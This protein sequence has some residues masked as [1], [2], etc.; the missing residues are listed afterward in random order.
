MTAEQ[1][2][3]IEKVLAAAMDLE[4]PE[5]C[6]YLDRACQ[7]RP[8]VRAEVDALLA[9]HQ[10][11]GDFIEAAIASEA[12][13]AEP[14]DA[15]LLSRRIG[16]YKL[17]KE[18][19]R[20]GMATV[21]LG[22]RDDRK[23]SKDVAIKL[24]GAPAPSPVSLR[25]FEEE[26]QILATLEHPNIARLLDGGVT[27]DG[28]HYI[29]MEYVEG[30][31]IDEYCDR[32]SLK[33]EQRLRLF[34]VICS[35]VYF[36]H[37]HLVVHRDIK[38][39]NI[40]VTAE[41]A[42]KLLDFGIAKILAPVQHATLTQAAPTLVPAMTPEYASPEQLQGGIVTTASD[43]Y[44]LGVLL[45]RLLSGAQPYRITGATLGETLRMVCEQDPEKPSAAANR[46]E[47]RG[48]LDAIVLKAMR[49][50]PRERY[51][52]PEEFAGDIG[53]YLSKWPVLARR[54]SNRY[55]LRKFVERHRLAIAITAVATL[56]TLAGVVGVVMESRVARAERAKAERRFNDVRR[57]A[58]SVI[59]EMHDGIAALPGSTPV[60][61]LLVTKATEYLD[62][63]A[64]E[65]RGDDSLQRELADAY[66]R[67]GD[68]QGGPSF[69]NL[70]DTKGAF[71][72]YQKA[73][74]ILQTVVGR[75][76]NMKQ[77]RFLLADVNGRLA[78]AYLAIH[79][80]PHAMD[81][82]KEELSGREEIARQSHQDKESSYAVA[83]AH[84]RLA[85]VMLATRK[86]DQ[87]IA[88]F[89]NCLKM[90]ESLLVT[91]P[92]D[93]NDQ[94]N[95][96]LDHKYLCTAYE[97]G[98]DLAKAAEHCQLA[99][100]LDERRAAAHPAD[101]QAK[102]DLGYSLS[103]TGT[104]YEKKGSL[105]AAFQSF[106]RSLSIR[107]AVAD[108]DPQNVSARASLVFPHLALGDVLT[109]MGKM[110]EAVGQ[111]RMAAQIGEPLIA[112]DP[113]KSQPRE[114]VARAYQKMGDLEVRLAKAAP[115]SSPKGSELLRSAC[116]D[117]GRARDRYR[118]NERRNAATPEAQKSA[119]QLA[120]DMSKVCGQ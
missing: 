29:I 109:D 15:Q 65:A 9:A 3:E 48:D 98:Y 27:D 40:L 104:I 12:G 86:L 95:L 119:Q 69:A 26:R 92:P 2:R 58:N 99:V 117:Y 93:V 71:V 116:T 87:A 54:G 64:K 53:R 76:P 88:E 22:T 16:A 34:Q 67:V 61:K 19:G 11:A 105:P 28:L 55:V 100:D 106:N 49:K 25:R 39:A 118:E 91:P 52:S 31:P 83:A 90:H 80:L 24:I 77:C 96:A 70:G 23:F 37:Q 50:E 84:F 79:D 44:S 17:V 46:P 120:H 103:Q 1:W 60:R 6:A 43:V 111:Y 10:Q 47:L 101:Q 32:N 14:L 73:R 78:S 20:G 18:L 21:Y 5:R 62:S 112:K 108:G 8:E 75:S 89:Q 4:E 82:V 97:Y 102:R 57:L 81:A 33:L 41:G 59:Y 110:A 66:I 72:S 107:Q 115:A 42:P 30:L 74:S 13:R 113:A 63:L 36:A 35:T 94:R 68:V 38:P 114:S 45:Y 56:L 51:S 7:G 85:Q